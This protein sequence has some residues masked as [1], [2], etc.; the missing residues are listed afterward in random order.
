MSSAAAT[1]QGIGAREASGAADEELTGAARELLRGG[2]VCFKLST[3][4]PA[5][6]L[7]RWKRAFYVTFCRNVSGELKAP[8]GPVM[9][10]TVYTS[11]AGALAECKTPDDQLLVMP[12]N[13]SYPRDRLDV[14]VECRPRDPADEARFNVLAAVFGGYAGDPARLEDLRRDAERLIE[15]CRRV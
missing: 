15:K 14:A 13:R 4:V 2:P 6:L 12:L 1:W 10:I 11:W 9:Q 5:G 3:R 8:P 7:P